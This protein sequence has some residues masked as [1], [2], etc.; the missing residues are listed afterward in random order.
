MVAGLIFSSD[1]QAD[2]KYNLV[3]DYRLYAYSE[4]RAKRQ[5]DHTLQIRVNRDLPAQAEYESQEESMRATD[6]AFWMYP[7][8]EML[9]RILFREFALS[10]LFRKVSRKDTKSDLILEVVLKSF[11]ARMQR[12]GF[13]TRLID[14]HVAL[15]ANLVQQKPRKTLFAKEYDR[16]TRVKLKPITKSEQHMVKQVGRCLEEIVP[17]LITDIEKVLEEMTPRK[18]ARKSPKQE[19]RNQ[20]S[21]KKKPKSLSLEPVGPK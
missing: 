2:A 19:P 4:Y 17:V 7:A 10:F 11:H 1:L 20:K 8:P 6:D 9:E 3:N 12:A 14:G 13:V 18:K 16:Q 21:K 5:Y 15:S